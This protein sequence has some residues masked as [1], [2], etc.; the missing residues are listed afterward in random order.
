[1]NYPEALDADLALVRNIE[2]RLVR[3]RAAVLRQLNRVYSG[4]HIGANEA[5]LLV[6][7]QEGIS[8]TPTGLS[9]RSRP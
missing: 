9:S 2:A 4:L 3:G 7:I 5:P 1:M 6:A 8:T